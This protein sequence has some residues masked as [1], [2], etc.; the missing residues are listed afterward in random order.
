V[1][2]ST[3][4]NQVLTLL[5]GVNFVRLAISDGYPKPASIAPFVNTL[6][7][8]G[9]VVEIEDH[10]YPLTKP[11]SGAALTQE[12]NWFTSLASYYKGNPRVWFGPQNEPQSGVGLTAEDVSVYSAI[13]NTGNNNPILFQARNV[14]SLNASA[15]AGMHN[16]VWDQHFY[17]ADVPGA[18]TQAAVDNALLHRINAIQTIH[19]ADGLVPVLVGEFGPSAADFTADPNGQL[20]IWAVSH[21]AVNNG[22]TSGFAGWFWGNGGGPDTMT[23]DNVHLT[24]W[25]Q[26][27]HNIIQSPISPSSPSV[28]SSSPTQLEADVASP[29]QLEADVAPSSQFE[30]NV[31]LFMDGVKLVLQAYDTNHVLNLPTVDAV[32]SEI[33]SLLAYAGPYG[34]AS[35]LHG[36]AVASSGLGG[37]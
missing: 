24:P 20:A 5:P 30:A 2:G 13:R 12:T 4:A 17:G 18:T 33:N 7:S 6:T 36:T 32:L 19:S 37:T 31:A 21:W 14:S 27:M 16:I 34:M 1:S 11:Y 10:N 22:Y 26:K 28:T 15:Y 23:K 3:G 29:S 9:V 8:H 25:G 35:L